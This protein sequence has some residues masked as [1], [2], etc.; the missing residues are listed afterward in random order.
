MLKEDGL[1]I[2]YC[3]KW[4]NQENQ[5]LEKTLKLLEG[6]IVETKSKFLPRDK[7]IRNAIFIK[8][9][10]PCPEIYPRSIGKAEKHPLKG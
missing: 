4:N 6:T 3:G 8:P 2:L 7:G 5:N 1:G 9:K 10:A